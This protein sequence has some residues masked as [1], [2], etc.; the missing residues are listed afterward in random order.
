[1][2]VLRYPLLL[3][4][5]QSA[6]HALWQHV[7]ED[8]AYGIAPVGTVLEDD[9][10]CCPVRQQEFSYS[11]APAEERDAQTTFD[12]LYGLLRHRRGLLR[13][14]EVLLRIVAA[15][16]EDAD[17]SLSQVRGTLRMQLLER[18]VVRCLSRQACPPAVVRR[19]LCFLAVAIL[20]KT[21]VVRSWE[22]QLLEEPCCYSFPKIETLHHVARQFLRPS[23]LLLPIVSP[24]L[25]TAAHAP[26]VASA[27]TRSCSVVSLWEAG[28]GSD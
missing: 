2:R 20:L 23:A 8:L 9:V 10:L 1:M 14:K 16:E 17:A 5:C 6:P 7:F 11:L 19:L 26:R 21:V 24:A 12:D 15:T 25:T 13:E 3:E 18:A 27:T 22:Q 4:C 28:V